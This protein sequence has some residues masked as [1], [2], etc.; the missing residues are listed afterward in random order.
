MG[1]V[2]LVLVYVGEPSFIM[3]LYAKEFRRKGV[4]VLLAQSFYEAQKMTKS[5]KVD[6]VFVNVNNTRL[7]SSD[8]ITKL[9][10]SL[11]I[12]VVAT[13]V[14]TSERQKKRYVSVDG[15]C[16]FIEEPLAIESCLEEIK[17]LLSL[18]KRESKRIKK[19]KRLHA[20]VFCS[21]DRTTVECQLVDLSVGGMKVLSP[22]KMPA[23]R[24]LFF[25]VKLE[26]NREVFTLNTETMIKPSEDSSDRSSRFYAYRILFVNLSA[27]E[28]DLLQGFIKSYLEG[29]PAFAF[30]A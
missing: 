4:K 14:V 27:K 23:G 9:S 30:Y 2:G 17:E 16:A 1:R 22:Q 26:L 28:R 13:G 29:S 21:F 18:P 7:N 20:K 24:S 3:E 5:E 15:A 11:D 8:M 19:E 6:L 25:V 10:Q 12:P